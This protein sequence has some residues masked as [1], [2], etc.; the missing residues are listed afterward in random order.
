M[1]KTLSQKHLTSIIIVWC[2][3]YSPPTREELQEF[4]EQEMARNRKRKI[5]ATVRKLYPQVMAEDHNMKRK[6]T[7]R[8]TLEKSKQEPIKKEKRKRKIKV[9]EYNTVLVIVCDNNILYIMFEAALTL[10]INNN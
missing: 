5:D 9:P 8:T 1:A 6:P 10:T 3:G 7:K 2:A 4:E